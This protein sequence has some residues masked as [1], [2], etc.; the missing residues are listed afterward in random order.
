MPE[1][2]NAALGRDRYFTFNH[3]DRL[4][5]QLEDAY[6]AYCGAVITL[7]E[8]RRALRQGTGAAEQ[9]ALDAAEDAYIEAECTL[10][11]CRLEW[12]LLEY[13]LRNGVFA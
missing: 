6:I 11:L 4:K 10:N 7:N 2:Q 5:G 9:D 8:A 3:L 13:K 1:H 12:Q